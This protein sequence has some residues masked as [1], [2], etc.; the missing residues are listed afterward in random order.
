MGR[1]WAGARGGGALCCNR[2]ADVGW[3][4]G[5]A[6]GLKHNTRINTQQQA[7][8]LRTPLIPDDGIGF[9]VGSRPVECERG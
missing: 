8:L 5:G 1:W 2:A 9:T 7:K 4:A 6:V 3:G